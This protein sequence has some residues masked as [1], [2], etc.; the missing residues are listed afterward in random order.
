MGHLAAAGADGL[1]RRRERQRP[2]RHQGAVLAQAV[3][4]HEVGL[5]AVGGEQP[6]ER[7]I[8]GQHGGLGDLGAAQIRFGGGDGVGVAGIDEEIGR[9]RPAE[10]RGHHG[11]RLVE[12]VGDDRLGVAQLG[13]HVGV[14]RALAGV[15][16]GDLRGRTAAAEDAAARAGPSSG[17]AGERGHRL[18]DLV[19]EVVGVGVVDGDAL[20][21]AQI[22]LGGAAAAGACPGDRVGMHR[23]QAGNERGLVAGAEHQ[24]ATQRSLRRRRGPDRS[25]TDAAVTGSAPDV[26]SSAPTATNFCPSVG[27]CPGT[28]SSSTAWKLVPPNPNALTPAVRT[29][30]V[31]GS[32]G[33]SS[34]LTTNG[35]AS[36]SML[37][38]SCLD[39]EAGRQLLV[40][41]RH[42]RLEEAGGSGGGLEVADVRLGRADGHRPGGRARRRRMPRRCS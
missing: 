12:G 1:E 5:D 2:G 40:M 42:D 19:G 38:F 6:G 30:S 33:R 20:G 18:L 21:G 8:D 27:T 16:E 35:D 31:G 3:T 32:H 39:V 17:L 11:V 36:Q 22:G 13:Q 23:Q 7:E 37:G 24:G 29:P 26:D 10:Q 28:Y 41:D 14:L 4:H 15:Q 9:Q 25:P 34:V